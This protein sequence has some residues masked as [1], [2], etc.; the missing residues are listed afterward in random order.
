M[1]LHLVEL[2]LALRDLHLWAGQRKLGGGFDEGVALHHLLGEVFGPATLQ[3]FRLMVAP[4]A[5]HGTLYAYARQNADGLR[6]LARSVLTPAQAAVVRLDHLRS[7]ARPEETW[8][9]GQKL[10]F[11]LR[12]RPVVR[13]ASALAGA[14]EDGAPVHFSKGA[15]VDAFLVAALRGTPAPREAVYRDWLA[16]RLASAAILDSDATRLASFRRLRIHR[17]NRRLEGP[18]VVMHGTLTVADPGAFADL[19]ERG[20]GRHRTYGYGMLLLRPPQKTRAC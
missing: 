12:L 8:A 14:A 11:D 20:I 7:L 3:P 10:G 4:Q 17:G 13:L 18:E 2:P 16:E 5:R 19:L 6:A 9:V 1:S 15:E